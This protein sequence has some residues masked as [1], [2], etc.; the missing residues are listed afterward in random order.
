MA[1]TIKSQYGTSNQTITITL[2]SLANN[3]ARA[4]TA[5][6]NTTN[7]FLDSLL[8]MKIKSN[9]AGTS[10]TGTIEVYAYGSSDGGTTYTESATGTDAAITL[11]VPTNARLIGVF[12]IVANATTYIAG[13]FSIASA[14]SGSLPAFYGIIVVNKSGAALDATGGSHFAIYQGI[15]AQG[16]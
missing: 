13:P 4:S 7:L 1:T 16:V 5:I 15:L 10:S 11:T 12:N 6:D 2:A 9:A 8:E 3:A 14:F